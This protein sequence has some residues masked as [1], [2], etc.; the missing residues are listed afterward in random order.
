MEARDMRSTIEKI[1]WSTEY[2]DNT[3]W[4][5]EVIIFNDGQIDL[6]GVNDIKEDDYPIQNSE[7]ADY[8]CTVQKEDSK[9]VRVDKCDEEYIPL[10]EI[11]LPQYHYYVK[12]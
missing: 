8:F 10:L 5:P 6:Y 12:Y 4:H 1:G 2:Y 9:N 7:S 3:P 11:A